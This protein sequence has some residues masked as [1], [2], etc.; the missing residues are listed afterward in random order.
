M[1]FYVVLWV[2]IG[3][4]LPIT[5]LIIWGWAL[6]FLCGGLTLLGA[7]EGFCWKSRL[8]WALKSHSLPLWDFR[9][10]NRL[11]F[12]QNPSNALRNVNAPHKNHKAPR[13]INNSLINSYFTICS[14][15]PTQPFSIG[16]WRLFR[17]LP[18]FFE[19]FSNCFQL[20]FSQYCYRKF[21]EPVPLS[22]LIINLFFKSL[23]YLYSSLIFFL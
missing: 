20:Y 7:L 8:F 18:L 19:F 17:A 5:L 2:L 15:L 11:D 3:I 16:E 23:N 6:W 10:Q 14:L 12:Q 22:F 9:A 4:K 21:C 13:Q 1:F